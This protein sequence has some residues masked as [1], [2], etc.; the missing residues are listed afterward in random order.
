MSP[1]PYASVVKTLMYATIY[2]RLD[3]SHA[4]GVLSGYMSN[5]E[6]KHWTTRKRIFR[7][8]HGTSK[9]MIYYQRRPV[10]NRVVDVQVF[11]DV[12]WARDL[13]Q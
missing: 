8:F 3:I 7:Y 6:K 12:D 11:V 4:M 5:L 13:D 10:P 9:Y 2:T 1:V